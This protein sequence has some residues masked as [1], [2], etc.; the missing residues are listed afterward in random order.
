[1]GVQVNETEAG[2]EVFVAG[3]DHELVKHATKDAGKPPVVNL[4]RTPVSVPQSVPVGSL[5][6]Q[7]RLIVVE[8]TLS[9]TN[10]HM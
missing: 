4:R 8:N 1:M 3:L 9:L 6:H 2:T 10:V 7:V 5:L